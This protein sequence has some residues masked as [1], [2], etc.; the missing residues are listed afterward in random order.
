MIQGY[1]RYFCVICK[2]T[3][4]H[5]NVSKYIEVLFILSLK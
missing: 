1:D 2:M 3:F 4:Y 5:S